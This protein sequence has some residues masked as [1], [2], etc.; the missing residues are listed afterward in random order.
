MTYPRSC[1][2][3]LAAWSAW[4]AE[5]QEAIDGV[6]LDADVGDFRATDADAD[7]LREERERR[8]DVEEER[9]LDRREGR[10]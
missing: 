5:R 8:R 6:L 4:E 1:E 9:E 2:E 7:A 3:A 10:R